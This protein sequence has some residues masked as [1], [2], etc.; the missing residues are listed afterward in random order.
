M[1]LSKKMVGWSFR[2][3]FCLFGLVDTLKALGIFKK[4]PLQMSLF[5]RIFRVCFDMVASSS[6]KYRF[7]NI[8]FAS[9]KW[10]QLQGCIELNDEINCFIWSFE[11]TLDV[12][13]N[14]S[15]SIIHFQSWS[16]QFNVQYQWLNAS[17]TFS[18]K[19]SS[20]NGHYDKCIESWELYLKRYL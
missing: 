7:R 19:T 12:P 15:L 18:T 10:M 4:N 6:S 5:L 8:R 1:I 16:K 14:S 9:F 17:L 13:P 2:T 11:S 20:P 3:S